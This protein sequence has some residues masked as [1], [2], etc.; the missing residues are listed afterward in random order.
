[1]D[2]ACILRKFIEGVTAMREGDERGEDNFGSDFMGRD[3]RKL[4]GHRRCK[5]TPKS[6]FYDRFLS[7]GYNIGRRR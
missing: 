7:P 4:L 6:N 2:Q 3:R 5:K 1:M